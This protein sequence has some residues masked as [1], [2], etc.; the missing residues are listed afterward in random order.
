MQIHFYFYISRPENEYR[1]KL[2]YNH[3]NNLNMKRLIVFLLTIIFVYKVGAQCTNPYYRLQEGTVIEMETYD[4]KDKLQ[5]RSE[6]SVI[7]FQETGTGYLATIH[8]KLLDKKEKLVSEGD[9]K[10]E[11]DN[12][13]IKIDMSSMIPAESMQ[14]FKDME[15]EVDMDQMLYPANLSVGQSLEDASITIKTKNSPVPMG[16]DMDISNR[17]V[18]GKESVTTPA[19]NFDCYKISY[20]T[21]SKMSFVKMNFRTVE[22]LSENSGIVKTESYKSNGNM[23]SYSV[24]TKYEY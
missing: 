3:Q 8:Y 4:K 1:L 10:F 5:S 24:L 16:M 22:Y 14:A 2:K 19:G 6:T 11:C 13:I 17:K 15:V 18:E 7:Q 21:F 20:D 9:Y 23:M 12:G